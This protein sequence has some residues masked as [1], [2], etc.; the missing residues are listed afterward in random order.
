MGGRAMPTTAFVAADGHVALVENRNYR[1][2]TLRQAI[3]EVLLAP[4]DGAAGP[5]GP[6]ADR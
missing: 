2:E 3:D 1:A 5:G 6:A 4:A